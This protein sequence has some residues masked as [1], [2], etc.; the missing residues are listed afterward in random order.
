MVWEWEIGLQIRIR[1]D[2][3]LHSSLE[4]VFRGPGTGSGGPPSFRQDGCF[5]EELMSSIRWRF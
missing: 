2:A 4:L 1:I 5:V 3:S